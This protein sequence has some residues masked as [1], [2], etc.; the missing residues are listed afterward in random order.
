MEKSG[1]IGGEFVTDCYESPTNSIFYNLATNVDSE[2]SPIPV[3]DDLVCYII[4]NLNY[5]TGDDGQIV[6]ITLES[7]L[8]NIFDFDNCT[9]TLVLSKTSG[10]TTKFQPVILKY[11][12][13]ATKVY[14]PYFYNI[15]KVLDGKTVDALTAFGILLASP[16]NCKIT[17]GDD[18]TPYNFF[19]LWIYKFATKILY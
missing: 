10:N 6:N 16:K 9:I 1:T 2:D 4:P 3:F 18:F 15:K 11:P 8:N 5:L 14:E 12:Y 7:N 19:T 17:I 13:N